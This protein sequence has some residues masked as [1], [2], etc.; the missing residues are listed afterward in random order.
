MTTRHFSIP[1]YFPDDPYTY[2]GVTIRFENFQI[3]D[4]L[5]QNSGFALL[6]DRQGYI[7][8]GTQ[9]GLNRYDGYNFK[10]YRKEIDNEN[11]LGTNLVSCITEDKDGNLW[12]GTDDDG[13]YF[14]DLFNSLNLPSICSLIARGSD[15]ILSW[16]YGLIL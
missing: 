8:I 14:F 16:G 13:I 9:E 4:G 2:P 10:V 11:M 15:C 1:E 3:E 6:Q 5:S 12:I 7:W